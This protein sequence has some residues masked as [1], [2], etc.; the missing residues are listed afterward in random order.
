MKPFE[1]PQ[2]SVKIFILTQLSEMYRVGRV[3]TPFLIKQLT[4]LYE[5]MQFES[6][7]EKIQENEF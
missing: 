1:A 2:R 7:A 5:S 4:W 6:T 3:N